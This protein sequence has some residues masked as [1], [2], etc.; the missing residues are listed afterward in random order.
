MGPNEHIDG[1]YLDVAILRE[2]A[3]GN[4]VGLLC[5]DYCNKIP[6]VGTY[7]S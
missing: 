6:V 4:R 5:R 7:P 1:V 3:P 2:Q